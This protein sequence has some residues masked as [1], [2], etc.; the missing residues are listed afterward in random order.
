MRELPQA[1]DARASNRITRGIQ[2]RI[3][4][5]QEAGASPLTSAASC[6]AVC[7][8]WK[9]SEGSHGTSSGAVSA[10]A[11][12]KRSSEA[13]IYSKATRKAAVVFISRE[14]DMDSPKPR[15]DMDMMVTR[16][17]NSCNHSWVQP[18]PNGRCP[19][20]RSEDV[21]NLETRVNGLKRV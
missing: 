17:C 8:H 11:G 7:S 6:L 21:T 19:K 3:N 5:S 13:A 2:W 14:I 10:L 1:Q 16:R 18:S 12:S 15:W 4:E 9:S 20:C